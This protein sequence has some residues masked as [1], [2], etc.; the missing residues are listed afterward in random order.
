MNDYPVKGIDVSKWQ[1]QINWSKALDQGIS[2]ALIRA[3]EGDKLIDSQF[4]RNMRQTEALRIPRGIYHYYRPDHDWRG[5]ASLFVYLV[6]SWQFELDAMVDIE[7]SGSLTKTQLESQVSKFVQRVE[8]ETAR[9]LMIYTSPGFFNRH[10]P[11]TDWAWQR[12]L[13]VAH[14]TSA[15]QPTIPSEWGN[16]NRTWTFWQHSARNQ[17]G[18]A[19]G[20]ATKS[21]DLDRFNGSPQEFMRMYKLASLPGFQDLPPDQEPGDLKEPVFYRV[22]ASNL[23]AF[24]APLL[25]SAI[26][27]ELGQGEV[28]QLLDISGTDEVWVQIAPERWV[29]YAYNGRNFLER[30]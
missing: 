29:L 8:S 5:Q 9:K 17:F 20:V 10:M 28:V 15:G 2:F 4:E 22:V 13:W 14:W 19:Y 30:V 23:H 27:G 1:K 6:Q 11:T 7:S 26:V 25:N 16:R 21:I 24:N 18:G 12:R 3:S